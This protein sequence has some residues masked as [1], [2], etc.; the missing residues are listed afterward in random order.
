MITLDAK[1]LKPEVLVRSV[2]TVLGTYRKLLLVV[3][4]LCSLDLK[5]VFYKKE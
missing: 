1:F 5:V 3:L 2:A 4:A